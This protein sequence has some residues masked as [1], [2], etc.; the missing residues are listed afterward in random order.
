MYTPINNLVTRG[1]NQVIT[2]LL[3]L[4]LIHLTKA[5]ARGAAGVVGCC[6]AHGHIDRD[7]TRFPQPQLWF[8]P[9]LSHPRNYG[10]A[11]PAKPQTKAYT[12]E[13][14]VRTRRLP[15]LQSL[16]FAVSHSSSPSLPRSR[17]QNTKTPLPTRSA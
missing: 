16:S 5:A 13:R 15:R 4:N 2:C 10:Y 9:S 14:S 1:Q 12:S 11:T 7:V 17:R 6:W 3:S 8:Q